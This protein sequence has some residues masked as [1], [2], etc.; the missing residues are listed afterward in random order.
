MRDRV[1]RRRT[2]ALKSGAVAVQ[3]ALLIPSAAL[4][5]TERAQRFDGP[6]ALCQQTPRLDLEVVVAF[7]LL[8]AFGGI[9]EIRP[10]LSQQTLGSASCLQAPPRLVGLRPGDGILGMLG[11]ERIQTPK[12]LIQAP[13]RPQTARPPDH[14]SL[15]RSDASASRIAS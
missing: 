13:E 14:G 15:V 9:E 11:D 5:R 4:R 2:V 8:G 7:G 12:R 3:R 10:V 1:R 6:V